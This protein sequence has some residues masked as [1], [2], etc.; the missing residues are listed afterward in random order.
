MNVAIPFVLG[1][2]KTL[3]CFLT[4]ILGFEASS[5]LHDG[6][7]G[8]HNSKAGVPVLWIV[9]VVVP[10]MLHPVTVEKQPVVQDWVEEAVFDTQKTEQSDTI[11]VRLHELDVALG[12]RSGLRD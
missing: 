12:V 2:G 10:V 7:S 9:V 3:F 8:E 4:D 6:Q 11:L 5:G 1:V